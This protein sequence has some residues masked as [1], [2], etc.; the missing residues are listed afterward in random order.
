[1]RAQ[2][3][4]KSGPAVIEA[5]S[6]KTFDGIF[7]NVFVYVKNIEVRTYDNP[8]ISGVN[9]LN[10]QQIKLENVF[11]NSAVYAAA[12]PRQPTHNGSAGV[13]TPHV[14]NGAMT[15]LRNVIVTGYYTGIVCNEHT[16]GDAINGN[17]AHDDAAGC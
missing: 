8:S 6:T 17:N 10:A 16:D 3:L 11:V 1:M 5:L 13:I 2:S 7:S 15:L 4:K 14:G 9:F 12:I